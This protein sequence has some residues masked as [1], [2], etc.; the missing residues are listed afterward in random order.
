M[1]Q[2]QRVR[3]DLATKQQQKGA[4]CRERSC[5]LLLRLEMSQHL[6]KEDLY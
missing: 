6:V 2:P 5:V 1:P 4:R 3:R